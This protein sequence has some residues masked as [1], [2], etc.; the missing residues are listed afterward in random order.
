[1]RGKDLGVWLT[2]SVN[3]NSDF[4]I[5]RVLCANQSCLCVCIIG[6]V[7][8][9]SSNTGNALCACI[10]CT[11]IICTIVSVYV[12][13]CLCVCTH[14]CVYVYVHASLSMLGFTVYHVCLLVCL[15]I[16]NNHPTINSSMPNKLPYLCNVLIRKCLACVIL[17]C[18]FVCVC[19]CVWCVVCV[20]V[21]VCWFVCVCVCVC[22]CAPCDSLLL[23]HTCSCSCSAHLPLSTRQ[24]RPPVN[25]VSVICTGGLCRSVF[26]TA[27]RM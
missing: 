18:V 6:R 14:V 24:R 23:R 10:V 15:I 2:S 16:Q 1:M 19:V 11:Y 25:I 7:C 27:S 13:L 26:M 20:C 3:W 12:Y 9:F 4:V 5:C 22:V 17:W 8:A 21:C